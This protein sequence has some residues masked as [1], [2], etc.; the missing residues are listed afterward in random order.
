MA[1]ALGANRIFDAPVPL[2]VYTFPEIA[3]VGL[4]EEQADKRNIPISV[5]AFPIGYL[6]K[7]MA[8]GHGEGMIKVI[9]DHSNDALLGVHMFGHNVTEVIAC[10]TA[11]LG[12][13]ATVTELAETIF[14]HPTISEAVKEAAEDSFGQAIHLPPKKVV[15][16]MAGVV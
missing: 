11:M 4:T 3:G 15:S 9:R 13:K 16:V 8:V 7:A 2:T 1:N 12:E 6:G 14:A 10:T 5:G